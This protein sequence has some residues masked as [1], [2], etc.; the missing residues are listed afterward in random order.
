MPSK[1]NFE[2]KTNKFFSNFFF[3]KEKWNLNIDGYFLSK[4]FIRFD[5]V[6]PGN[7]GTLSDQH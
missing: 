1:Q 5:D 3:K 7:D 2:K 6:Q 4:F